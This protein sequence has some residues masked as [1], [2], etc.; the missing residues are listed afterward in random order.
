MKIKNLRW[1]IVVLVMLGTITNYLARSTLGV[2]AP[3]MMRTLGLSSEQ[4]SWIV[5]VFP[6]YLCNRWYCMRL[7]Y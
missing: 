6:L 4:Y 2:A 7:H 3:E 5:S 1:Y